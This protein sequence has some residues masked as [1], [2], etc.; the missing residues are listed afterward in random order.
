MRP[1]AR[2]TPMF[3]ILRRCDCLALRQGSSQE[4]K[5]AVAGRCLLMD[6][7]VRS[8]DTSLMS[9]Q[10]SVNPDEPI[11]RFCSTEDFAASDLDEFLTDHADANDYALGDAL[12]AEERMAN[13]AGNGV[14]ARVFGLIAGLMSLHMRV[15]DPAEIFGP[16]LVMGTRRSM[17]PSD[18]RGPQTD[19]LAIQAGLLPHPSVRARVGDVAFLNSRRH[20][21]AGRAAMDAYCELAMGRL[22]GAFS[23]SIMGVELG[24][25]DVVEPIRRALSLAGLLQRRGVV[26]DNVSAAYQRAWDVALNEERYVQFVELAGA[27]VA[28][29]LITP[30][31]A[32]R[33]AEALAVAAPEGT[34]PEAVKRA[35]NF[36]AHHLARLG[37]KDGANRC[38]LAAV[39][40]TLKMRDQCSGSLARADWTKDAIGELRQIPGTSARVREL[41]EEMRH[42]QLAAQD[43]MA[44]FEVP[45]DLSAERADA[46]RVFEGVSLPEAFVELVLLVEPRSADELMAAARKDAASS[47]VETLFAASYRDSEGKEIKRI[48]APAGESEPDDDWLTAACI[49]QMS[50]IRHQIVMGYL[51]P[52]RRT[53]SSRFTVEDRHFEPITARSP[54]VPQGHGSLFALGFARMFQG[55]FVSAAHLLFPQLE[56][57][58]RHLLVLSNAE[59][60]K[61]EADLL[62]GDRTLSAL[63]GANRLDLERMWG[64]DIVFEIDILFNFRPGPALRNDL[65]HGKL[66]WGALHSAE[67]V[68]GCWFIFNLTCRPLFQVWQEEIAPEIDATL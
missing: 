37:D 2:A 68:I 39:E 27:G 29:G 16:V 1:I 33:D 58:L 36:A 26:P 22:D 28:A 23:S 59:P 57:S 53:I 12:R 6:L 34:Y 8:E 54:F 45:M 3:A 62:Q 52:A 64:K 18:V 47:I 25:H 48:A 17:I 7:T 46:I 4:T 11:F 55:D 43:E 44:S 66:T 60:S 24:L 9:S 14:R 67:V 21:A 56:N 19:V 35:W 61:I 20:H 32:A 51:E 10:D 49:R 65:S 30:A 41:M 50:F 13:A 42:L 40:Q 5:I 15:D 63:L 31:D 38:G